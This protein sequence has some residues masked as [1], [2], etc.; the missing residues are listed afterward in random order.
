MYATSTVEACRPFQA[1]THRVA[2]WLCDRQAGQISAIDAQGCLVM[3]IPADPLFAA[4]LVAAFAARS[5]A[6]PMAQAR[7]SD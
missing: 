3:T 4:R 7:L 2:S 1:D 6:A 5:E